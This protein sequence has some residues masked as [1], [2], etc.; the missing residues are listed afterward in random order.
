[1]DTKK[2]DCLLAPSL[3]DLGNPIPDSALSSLPTIDYFKCYTVK[4]SEGS[5]FAEG[6]TVTIKDQF[7]EARVYDLKKPKRL[8]NPV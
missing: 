4:V 3:K 6:Q 5:V 7:G 8:C 1:M 2:A